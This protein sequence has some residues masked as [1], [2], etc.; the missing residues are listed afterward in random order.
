[1]LCNGPRIFPF[2]NNLKDLD[3]SCIKMDLGFFGLFWKQ[4]THFIAELHTADLNLW[5]F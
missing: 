3:P 5:Q 1:M 2:Q 4:N